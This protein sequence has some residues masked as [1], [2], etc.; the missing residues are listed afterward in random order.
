[1]L[2][3]IAIL[4]DFGT[5]DNYNAVMEA[6]IKKFNRDTDITYITQQS[7]NFNVIA[8]SYLLFTSYRYFRK[9]TIFLVV[10][11][12]GV[13]TRRRPLAVKTRQY[14]FIGPDNGILYPTIEEDGIERAYSIDNDKVYLTREIS[15]TFH[16]RDIFSISA[17]LLSRKVP[18]ETLGTEINKTELQKID[19]RSRRENGLLCSKV[20]YVDHFG[21]VSLA[22]RDA[23]VRVNQ[24][25][26]VLVKGRTFLALS[27][28]TFQDS[29]GELIVYRNGYGFL[30]LGLNKADASVLLDVKEGD[31]I[32]IEES[33]LVDFNPFT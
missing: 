23:R 21:N 15:N 28:Q 33:I 18:I 24:R 32:C 31:D 14:F 5:S 27:A 20:F 6:V 9:N 22:I 4:T 7:K 29:K 2:L 8:G 17:A 30:E 12:P 19:L 1:M 13:G 16:G 25:V 26:N 3:T 11:D 10:V